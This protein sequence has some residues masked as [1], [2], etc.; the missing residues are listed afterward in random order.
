MSDEK[1][2]RLVTRSDT[3]LH[4]G[5]LMLLDA[6]VTALLMTHPRP[7]HLRRDFTA[8]TELLAGEMRD[9]GIP[10]DVIEK[11][12]QRRQRML[13]KIGVTAVR[14]VKP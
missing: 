13:A 8:I 9:A 11:L 4:S 5:H 6:A 12:E 14:S 2:S 1:V 7:D 3:G 10:D